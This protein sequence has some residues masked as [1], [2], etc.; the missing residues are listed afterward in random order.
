M[1]DTVTLRA[2]YATADEQ[3][4]VYGVDTAPRD[5]AEALGARLAQKLQKEAEHP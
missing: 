5:Q 4:V 3:T 2:M 1:D